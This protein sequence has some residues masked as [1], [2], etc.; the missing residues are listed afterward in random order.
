MK[1]WLL[2][3]DPRFAVFKDE[4]IMYDFGK[5]LKLPQWMKGSFDRVLVDPPFLSEDCQTKSKPLQT[6]VTSFGG[7]LVLEL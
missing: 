1:V 5:P 4:F 7:F 3:Y 2:E 6:P